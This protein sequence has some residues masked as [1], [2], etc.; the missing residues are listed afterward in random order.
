VPVFL[1]WRARRHLNPDRRWSHC[2]IH[3]EWKTACT[4]V[5]IE[6]VSA[7]PRTKHTTATDLIRLGRSLG[8]VQK[9]LGHADP[10]STGAY[11]QLC[12]DEP[13][14]MIRRRKD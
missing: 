13:I 6:G 9:L 7:Y 10:H 3:W 11:V 12:N 8:A 1:N 4:A 14:D 2:S 5:G